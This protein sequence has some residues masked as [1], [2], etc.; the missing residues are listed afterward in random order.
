MQGPICSPGHRN[1]SF[2]PVSKKFRA[3]GFSRREETKIAQGGAKRNPGKTIRHGRS[4][5]EGWIESSCGPPGR[6]RAIWP[7][8]QGS[9]ALH[10]GLFSPPPYGRVCTQACSCSDLFSPS[11]SLGWFV[12]AQACCCPVPL[13]F[14]VLC[15]KGGKPQMQ[16]FRDSTA[17]RRTS[18]PFR[19]LKSIFTVAVM[20]ASCDP[21]LAAKTSTPQGWGTQSLH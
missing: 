12:L 6:T 16:L 5:P 10:P 19:S 15:E 17:A 3:R 4:V 20:Q 8:T 9:A 13:P 18:P 2:S 11:L 21:T 1:T 7:T 14:R